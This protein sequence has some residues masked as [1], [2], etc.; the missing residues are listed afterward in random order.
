[1]I[2]KIFRR[3]A[4]EN[5]RKLKSFRTAAW[6]QFTAIIRFSTAQHMAAAHY[7]PKSENAARRRRFSDYLPLSRSLKP[8]RFPSKKLPDAKN[9]AQK[10]KSNLIKIKLRL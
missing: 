9:A 6:Q 5:R 8:R 3:K 4:R 10:P 7:T 1:M 2:I